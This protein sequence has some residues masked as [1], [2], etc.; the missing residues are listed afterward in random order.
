MKINKQNFIEV[1]GNLNSIINGLTVFFLCILVNYTTFD[2]LSALTRANTLKKFVYK[3]VS[4]L[5]KLS[6]SAIFYK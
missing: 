1:F 4:C 2:I 5:G 6:R 3:F